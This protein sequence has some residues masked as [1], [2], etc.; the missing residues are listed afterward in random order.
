MLCS[1]LYYHKTIRPDP[2]F[3]TIKL[4][5]FIKKK[6]IIYFVSVVK[7]GQSGADPEFDQGGPRL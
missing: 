3:I 7:N 2:K 5:I 4:G 6:T 1:L